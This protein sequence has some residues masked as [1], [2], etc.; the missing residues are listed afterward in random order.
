MA[1][2]DHIQVTRRQAARHL[3]VARRVGAV[4]AVIVMAHVSGGDDH[5]RFFVLAQLLN[6]S[7]RLLRRHAE[8][9]IGEVFRVADLGGVVGGQA[10]NRN[11][12]ALFVE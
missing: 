3:D 4:V 2:D 1:A 8:L 5:V 12:D 7:F 10:D 9:D 6:H 11:L